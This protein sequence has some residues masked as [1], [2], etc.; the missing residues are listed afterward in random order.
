M[1]AERTAEPARR[2]WR[3]ID[4]FQAA[5]AYLAFAVI[6]LI[7]LDAASA[8]GGRLG[9]AFGPRLKVSERARSNLAAAFPEMSGERIE[10]V[11]RGMW[12]NLGRTVFEFPHLDHLRFDGEEPHIEVVGAE[13]IVALRDDGRPGIFFSAHMANWEVVPL[14]AVRHGLSIDLIYRAPNNPWMERLFGR[15]HRGLGE[16]IAKGAPGARRALAQLKKGSHLGMLVDQK[17]NDGIAVPFFGRDAMTAPALA[18][19]AL[20]FDLPAVPARIERLGGARFRITYFPPL[21]LARSGDREA[22]VAAIMAEVNGLIESWV[23]ERPEQWLWL[24]N[25]WPD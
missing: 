12:D 2:R 17:M 25:R 23:R 20:K 6:G 15:R 13:H 19:F 7:P 16:L 8:L 10:A 21:E 4:P 11:V 18:L 5:L 22:D 14:C 3:L 24:H 9:R 1:A